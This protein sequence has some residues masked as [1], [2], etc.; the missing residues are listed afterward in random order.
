LN[1]VL[2]EFLERYPGAALEIS[3]DGIVRGSNGL[4][5]KMVGRELTGR[6]FTDVLDESSYH[7]WQALLARGGAGEPYVCEL[8]FTTPDSIE[9]RRFMALHGAV[10]P[11]IWLVEQP[12]DPKMEHLYQELTSLNAELSSMQRTVARERSR[13]AKALTAAENAV[14]TRDDVLAIVSHDLRNPMNT[15]RMAAGLLEMNIREDMKADQV[16]AIIRS[17]D[18]MTALIAD[19]L[20]VSAMEAGRFQ[21]EVA[22][23]DL[24]VVLGELCALHTTQAAEKQLQLSCDVVGELPMVP[25]DQHRLLQALSNLVGNAIKFTRAGGRVRVQAQQVADEV[26]ISVEDDGPG[27]SDEDAVRV[28]DRFWHA[29]RTSSGGTGLGLAITKGIADAHG[30]RIWVET[31]REKGAKLTLALGVS[32]EENASARRVDTLGIGG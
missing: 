28:F 29:T 18:R 14:R 27:I 11:I 30:G 20:D 4:L 32:P 8:A 19:L 6:S 2:H 9:A 12:R 22:P 21:I 25:G 5:D 3:Q 7:K 10:E 26:Q 23:T 24:N 16:G 31:G 17:V 1:Q 13:L 15:I